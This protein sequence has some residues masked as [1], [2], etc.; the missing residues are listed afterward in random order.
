MGANAS[1]SFA[2]TDS[3]CR[4]A[5]GIAVAATDDKLVAADVA[6]L[7]ER[8]WEMT[9]LPEG[10]ALALAATAVIDRTKSETHVSSLDDLQSRSL[11]HWSPAVERTALDWPVS[12]CGVDVDR[13]VSCTSTHPRV[14]APSS[15]QNTDAARPAS[16]S[17]SAPSLLLPRRSSGSNSRRSLYLKI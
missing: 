10:F 9:P 15:T 1:E 5:F 7:A 12:A 17:T 4:V 16:V 11:M 14:P 2:G 3:D 6:V 8:Q 13:V